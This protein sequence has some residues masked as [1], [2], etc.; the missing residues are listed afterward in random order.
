MSKLVVTNIRLTRDELMEYRQLALSEGKSFSEYLRAVMEQF[1]HQK[2]IGGKVDASKIDIKRKRSE[3]PI[4]GLKA[5][6]SGVKD[7]AKDHDKYIY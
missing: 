2:K 7:G 4:W 3:E 5:W 1:A 6:N